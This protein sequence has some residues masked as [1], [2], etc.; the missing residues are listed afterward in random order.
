[1]GHYTG[2]KGRV[3][4]RLSFMIF[5][6]NGARK[7]IERR[8]S[9]PGMHVRR[10]RVS[11]YGRALSEKQKIKYYYG[12]S[13]RQ[14]RRLY[15]EASRQPGNTGEALLVLCE[16]R[17]DNVIRLAGFTKTR[18]Q[19][20]QG[21]AHGHFQIN[22]RKNDIPATLVR[23]GDVVSVKPRAA[24]Q[25]MYHGILSEEGITP[26]HWLS[27][28]LEHLAVS[29]LQRPTMQDVTLPVNIDSVVEFLSR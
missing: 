2:A 20:R 27:V 13:E 11:D 12:L 3:N 14:L 15:A 25:A 8:E 16:L 1:M 9:P 5:E 17:L 26:P 29:V 19:A 4:R 7:A 23:V 6:N 28:D 21:V 18:P 10:G 24:F 22:G